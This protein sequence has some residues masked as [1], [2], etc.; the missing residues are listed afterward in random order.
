M[1]GA[2]AAVRIV[3]SELETRSC[4]GEALELFVKQ[5]EADYKEAQDI[6]LFIFALRC[7]FSW[8][9]APELRQ[10]HDVVN[11]I[12]EKWISQNEAAYTNWLASAEDNPEGLKW[13]KW[14]FQAKMSLLKEFLE[15][16]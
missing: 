3:L 10:N 12:R 16:L 6:A 13:A 11:A 14:T 9:R 8:H 7:F 2:T 15:Q 1:D 4:V 5:C